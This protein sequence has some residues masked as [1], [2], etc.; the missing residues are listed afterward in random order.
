MLVRIGVVAI[1]GLLGVLG[2]MLITRDSHAS[3][4]STTAEVSTTAGTTTGPST[5]VSTST[6]P[7]LAPSPPVAVPVRREVGGGCGTVGGVIILLPGRRPVVLNPL[8]DRVRRRASTGA[9]VFP[10]GGAVVSTEGVAVRA[11]SC[12]GGTRASGRSSV[13]SPSL[14][15]GVVTAAGVSLTVDGG[16]AEAAVQRLRIGGKPVVLSTGAR[17]PVAGWGYAT[18]GERRELAAGSELQTALAVH[19]LTANAGLPSGAIVAIGFSVRPK[20]A[21][22]APPQRGNALR[23]PRTAHHARSQKR[24]IGTR[25]KT[26]AR[27]HS[28]VSPRQR[29]RRLLARLRRAH[30]PLTLT[31]PLGLPRYVF[32]VAGP[33]SFI[34]SYGAAR[35]DVS[36]H[37]GDDIFA[38]LGTPVVAVA[39]GTLNR[40][41]WERLGGWRLWVRDRLAN[42]FYYAHLSG[43]T[44]TA[45]RGTR[46]RAGQVLGYVGDTGDAFGT[47]FHLHFEIHPRS[48]L[49]LRYDGAVDPTTYLE[50][51]QRLSHLRG[52]RPLHPALPTGAAR[53]EAIYVYRELLA[54]RGLIR[55][56]PSPPPIRPRSRADGDFGSRH[57]GH[58]GPVKT[59]PRETQKAIAAP[60]STFTLEGIAVAFLATSAALATTLF[61]RR[62][63]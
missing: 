40:V 55:R 33:A 36:W 51:W 42:E 31:P 24:A 53:A 6:A 11:G 44:G 56:R 15:G 52:S 12:R 21:P 34:D 26:H 59:R 9:F 50:H 37:H 7:V 49:S 10:S 27:H 1:A 20:L 19:L 13:A 62:S 28:V 41:G 63:R 60:A 32:P 29:R 39:D 5:A 58:R 30:R 47:P 3:D 43:Y 57:A 54:A 45:L 35:S 48:L 14:F 46:V 25:R 61:R 17:A 23:H 8:A 2:S 22:A 18:K 4:G 38:P 16:K